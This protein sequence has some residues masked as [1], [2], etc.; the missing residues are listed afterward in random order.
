[1][2]NQLLD[3]SLHELEKEFSNREFGESYRMEQVFHWIFS[4]HQ[5]TFQGM[6]NLPASFRKLLDQNYALRSLKIIKKEESKLDHTI[7]FTFQT[8]DYKNFIAVLLPHKNYYTLCISTQVGCA[9]KCQFCASGL[10]PYDRNLSSG[11]ILDQIFLIEDSRNISLK[12]I[13]FMGMGEPLA[14]YSNVLKTIQW[15]KSPQGFKIHPSHITLSTTGVV[16]QIKKLAKERLN[17]NLALSLHSADEKIRKKIMP[18]SSKFSI[19]EVLN[20]CKIYQLE[21]NSD[22]TI[23]YILL[24]KVNDQLKD[25]KTLVSVLNSTHF[26][27]KPK[28]NLIPYNSVANLPFKPSS[29][30]NIENFYQFLKN[31]GFIVHT[32]KPQGQDIGAACGQ[33]E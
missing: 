18:V 24:N 5:S 23:E 29:Q 13:L 16:P 11:E 30:E 32:R 10:V 7:K 3:L 2:K 6:T 33:L 20:A 15:L 26:K 31:K 1:M 28:I 14:N 21:N 9:F 8:F 12:N 17:V 27:G 25:A 4:Q 19:P 22:L